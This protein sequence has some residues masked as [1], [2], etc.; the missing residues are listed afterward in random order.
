MLDQVKFGSLYD[1]K[2]P[3]RSYPESQYLY[4]WA[5]YENRAY[6]IGLEYWKTSGNHK[7]WTLFQHVLLV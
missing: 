3:L 6:V 7:G 1:L 5:S 2:G 4:V